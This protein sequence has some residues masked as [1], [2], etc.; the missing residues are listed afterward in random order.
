MQAY[1]YKAVDE[2]GQRTRGTLTAASRQE[3]LERLLGQGV[4]VLELDETHAQAETPALGRI[5][6]RRLFKLSDLTRQLA[7]LTASGVPLMESMSVL[8]EQSD[9]EQAREL[10][11]DILESVKTGM[12]LSDAL[13]EHRDEFPDMMISM[14][15]MGEVSGTLDEVLARL[16]ELFEKQDEI[17]GE[18][19]AALAYPALVLLLGIAS[20]IFLV[21]FVIPRLGVLFEGLG[22]SLPLPTRILLGISSGVQQTWWLIG[23]LIVGGIVGFRVAFRRP[24]VRYAWDKLK[25]AIPWAGNMV[26]QAAIARFA[27]ALGTL[28]HA[29]VPMVEA[30]DISR[31]AVG[32]G[33]IARALEDIRQKVQGGDSLAGLMKSSGVFPPLPVQMV[34]VGEETGHL[35]E[36]LIRVAEAYDRQ[37]AA[38]TR[39]MT[40]MLA[41]ALILCVAV[42]VAFIIIALVLPIFRIS[43]GIG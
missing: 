6:R 9:N 26:R 17:R 38:S 37:T 22:E 19:K 14:V 13:A 8:I 27:R 15:H 39:M 30:L 3:A 31:T 32:S 7:T 42:V 11:S 40:S 33:P 36:M 20:A 16:A 24:E 12:S 29:D 21:A 5:F 10:L 4:H 1:S 34:A 2:S 28:V 41:P 35:D 18:V 25:L 23:L 43:A